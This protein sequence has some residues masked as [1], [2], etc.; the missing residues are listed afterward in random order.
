MLSSIT[1]TRLSVAVTA[2]LAGLLLW[3]VQPAEQKEQEAP[4]QTSQPEP[5]KITRDRE[6]PVP[7]IVHLPPPPSPTP[8]TP[9]VEIETTVDS[10]I[11]PLIPQKPQVEMPVEVTDVPPLQPSDQVETPS[12]KSKDLMAG[13]QV[14]EPGPVEAPQKVTISKK[15]DFRKR[16]Q[17]VVS[18]S[19]SKATHERPE[20]RQT[21]HHATVQ[22]AARGRALLRV[23]EH[24]KGPSIQISW[25]ENEAARSQLSQQLRQCFG[26]QLALM[27]RRGQLFTVDTARGTAWSPNRDYYSGFVRQTAGRLPAPERQTARD[28][29]RQHGQ[30]GVEVHIFPRRVDAL[31]LGALKSIAGSAY[32]RAKII[33][34]RYDLAGSRLHIKDFRIDGLSAS[35]MIDLT[36]VRHC[37]GRFK[38]QAS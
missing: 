30:I 27:D 24:G 26:M 29:R 7:D 35:G 37:Q 15:P 13:R 20:P 2:L 6:T 5:E 23:L 9:T 18:K 33:T 3:Q 10:A 28:I 38:G 21:V 19:S 25:P 11:T 31:M 36:G 14:L 4:V 22:T 17:P 16:L 12:R 32:D 8:P 34:A 1:Q